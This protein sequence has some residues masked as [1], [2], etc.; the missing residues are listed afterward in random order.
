VRAVSAACRHGFRGILVAVSAVMLSALVVP[1][2]FAAP[3]A[4]SGP[5]IT[6]VNFSGPVGDYS[7]T[8][9]GS[10]F[11]TY[12]GT[13]PF[14]GL[15]PYLCILDNA[16]VGHGEYGCVAVSL[17]FEHWSATRIKVG[18]FAGNPGDAVQIA[19]WSPQ[20]TGEV[21]W[22]GNVPGGPKRPAVRSVSVSGSGKN[23]KFVITGSGFGKA[24][25]KMPH[26]GDLNSLRLTD[27]GQL[28]CNGVP[29]VFEAGFSGW[30]IN[31]PDTI[32]VRYASWSATKIVIGG[33]SG[34]YGAACSTAL[35]G[36]PITIGI[37]ASSGTSDAA[38]QTA[39]AGLAS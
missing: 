6:S 12:R 5:V 36:D 24:P 23:L 10:G 34:T 20:S 25:A 37:Y 32:T 29:G 14:T 3:V 1:A 21:A 15:L 22:A 9:N 17:T 26:I 11:G 19:I 16:Q 35:A 2:A 28:V 33:F 13:I 27:W 8:I 39:W 7:V 30:G 4:P 38:P 18:G 31:P